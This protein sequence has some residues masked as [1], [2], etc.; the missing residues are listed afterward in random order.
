M[1]CLSTQK[2]VDCSVFVEFKGQLYCSIDELV[3]SLSSFSST[4]RKRVYEFDH[5][6]L[7]INDALPTAILYAQMGTNAFESMHVA[8]ATLAKEG[9]LNYVLRHYEAVRLWL[10]AE[11]AYY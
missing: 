1:E 4:D 7:S 9:K 10:S 8:M 2:G 11:E 3:S 6:Y 5:T